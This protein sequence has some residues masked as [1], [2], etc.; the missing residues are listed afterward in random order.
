MKKLLS[1][2]IICSVLCSATGIVYA[3]D[4]KAKAILD[5]LSKKTKSYGTIK[6]NFSYKME[7][8]DKKPGDTQEGTIYLKGNKYKLEIAN[9]EVICDGKSVWTYLREANEVQVNTMPAPGTD[10]AITPANIFTM[11]EKGFKYKYEGEKIEGGKTIQTITLHPADPKTKPYHSVKLF[12]D[13]GANQLSSIKIFGK[14]G[15]TTTYTVKNFSAN[16]A[17]Q[18]NLFIFSTAQHPKVE[19]IDLRE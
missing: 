1:F 14:D 18:D 8:A 11:Y 4:A 19:V 9:Q 15:T 13:K 6:A 2:I 10:D 5:A 3:Q 16:P 12:I 7:G 17:L